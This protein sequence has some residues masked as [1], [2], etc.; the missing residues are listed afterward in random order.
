MAFIVALRTCQDQLRQPKWQGSGNITR[1]SKSQDSP[2]S[3]VRIDNGFSLIFFLGPR[4]RHMDIPRLGVKSELPAYTTATATWDPSLI[5]DLH[6]SSQRHQSL[7]HWARPGIE[8][9]SSRMLVGFANC[10]A[11]MGTPLSSL[12]TTLFPLYSKKFSEHAVKNSKWIGF[13]CLPFV[14]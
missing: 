12:D 5:F 13:F 4:P 10:W 1:R 9:T 2:K 3:G 8:P 11:T 7:T 6:H 14:S